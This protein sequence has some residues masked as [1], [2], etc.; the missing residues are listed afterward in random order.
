MN[1]EQ[2]NGFKGN[3][4]KHTID[5]RDFIQENYTPYEGD[6]SFLACATDSTTKLWN[7]VMELYKQERDN[8][9][10]LDADTKTPSSVNAFDAGYIDKDLEK[11]VG[12]QTDAPL[13]RAIMPNGGIKIVEKSCEAYG[14]KVDSQTDYV[15]NNLRKTHNDGVFSVYS[16]DIRA[17]RS[18]HL[19]TGLPDGY[20]RGRIIGDYRRVALYGVDALITEKQEELE[21]L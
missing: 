17:A 5:V 1:F 21:I 16:P 18:S 4:W 14:Y 13:K 7:K 10:V 12:L 3:T 19:L 11:I 15:Y 8:G 20:G 2:W 6:S 9:G